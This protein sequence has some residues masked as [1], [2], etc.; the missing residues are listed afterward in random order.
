MRLKVIAC[1]ALSREVYFS[2]AQSPH[3]V[4][5]ELLDR[6]LHEEPDRLRLAVQAVI[7]RTDSAAY[8]AIALGLALCSNAAASLVASSKPL[9][10]PRAHDCI[11]LMLG[12]RKRYNARFRDNPGTYYYTAGWIER[13]GPDKERVTVE[14]KEA[15]ERIFREYVD[16]F[17]E[18][19]A[20]YLM[21]VLHSWHKNYNRAVFIS[22]PVPELRV[23]EGP[24]KERAQRIAAEHGWAYEEAEG[25][26]SLFRK[27]VFGEWN[28]DEFL[29]IPPGQRIEPSFDDLVVRCATC[30]DASL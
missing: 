29:V 7:D 22:S 24:A 6:S 8:D 27:L 4:D 3:V 2:A 16:K 26:L 11:T 21:D 12:S 10:L 1:N 13:A 15:R 25:D 28:D 9:V 30:S 14:G 17:G 5:V 23:V 19:N 20:L 18:E